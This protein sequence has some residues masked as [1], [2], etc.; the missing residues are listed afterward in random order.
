ME[1]EVEPAGG[2]E[3]VDEGPTGGPSVQGGVGVIVDS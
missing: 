1:G 3:D 2:E